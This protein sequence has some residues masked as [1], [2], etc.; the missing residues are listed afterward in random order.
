MYLIL[1]TQLASNAYHT[2][3]DDKNC[4]LET[5]EDVIKYNDMFDYK[6]K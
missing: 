1:K 3:N 4:V 6:M 5:E 2:T